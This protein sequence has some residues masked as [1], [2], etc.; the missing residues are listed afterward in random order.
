MRRFEPKRRW[1]FCARFRRR[2]AALR[3]VAPDVPAWLEAIIAR[4]MAKDPAH[5]FQTAAEIAELLGRCLAHVQQ[6]LLLA[7][8][9]E[10]E[11]PKK[12]VA[13]RRR[14][15]RSFAVIAAWAAVA[16]VLA[17]GATLAFKPWVTRGP[18]PIPAPSRAES[19]E[20]RRPSYARP[21]RADADEI[22][23]LLD[24]AQ[25]AARAIEV[26][27][28]GRDGEPGR[29]PL[30]ATSEAL[31]RYAESLERDILSGRSA[32]AH[33]TGVFLNL[34]PYQRSEP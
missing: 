6:P 12:P 3:E 5:R 16:V 34:H 10:W 17:I 26:E 1:P 24:Q 8:P 33:Q 23:H 2:A 4:L 30:S 15:R 31:A 22:Q 9:A 11:H 32:S 14:L 18:A 25:V 20:P 19:P 29:D 21:D 7:L 28:R 13:P 27:I